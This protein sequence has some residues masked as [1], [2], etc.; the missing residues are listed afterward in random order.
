MS[1]LTATRKGPEMLKIFFSQAFS[2][3]E[4]LIATCTWCSIATLAVA[5]NL[6]ELYRLVLV[7]TPLAPYFSECITSEVSLLFICYVAPRLHNMVFLE[8]Q[9]CNLYLSLAA[10]CMV[11]LLVHFI[12]IL[13]FLVFSYLFVYWLELVLPTHGMVVPGPGW[14]E[15]R[16]HA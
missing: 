13:G 14:H 7:D 15:H 16:N 8:I 1:Q 10:S 12:H 11:W 4:H 6:R 3:W 2:Y 9:E 5:Q